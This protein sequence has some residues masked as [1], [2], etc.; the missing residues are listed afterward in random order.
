MSDATIRDQL[1]VLAGKLQAARQ[2]QHVYPPGHPKVV[3]AQKECYATVRAL[4]QRYGRLQLAYAEDEFVF[5]TVQIPARS[6]TLAKFARILGDVGVGRLVLL[7]GVRQWEVQRF[8]DLLATERSELEARGG[9]ERALGDAGIEH[10]EA[11]PLSVDGRRH[12]DPDVLFR[13]WE[14]Y[15]TGLRIVRTLRLQARTHG[16]LEGLEEA[17]EFVAQLVYLGVRETRPLLA[18]HALKIHDEYS[19]THSVNVAMLTVAMACSLG[20]EKA[21][22][23]AIGLAALLH[24]IGKERVPREILQ[25][26]GTLTPEEWQVMKRHSLLGAQMRGRKRNFSSFFECVV[27]T[28]GQKEGSFLIESESAGG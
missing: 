12:E 18:V 15:S 7:D 14:A 21:Q 24:D 19:F 20:F 10:I 11:G 5:G 26:P 1:H 9:I 27:S 16:V 13:T 6:E 22:L 23:E 28:N 2:V 17:K 3:Q 8:L 25:K 4:L